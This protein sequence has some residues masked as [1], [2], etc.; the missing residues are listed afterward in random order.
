[1]G[2]LNGESKSP[3]FIPC[4][5]PPLNP[6]SYDLLQSVKPKTPPQLRIFHPRLKT[7]P[8]IEW[9]PNS[10]G[11]HSRARRYTHINVTSVLEAIVSAKM[12]IVHSV[13]ESS[14]NAY[15]K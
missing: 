4:S 11:S 15:V 9:G 13:E 14:V 3:T 2:H 7:T 12:A 10:T 8:M 5:R 6:I 1:M